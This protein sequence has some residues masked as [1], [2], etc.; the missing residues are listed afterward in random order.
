MAQRVRIGQIDCANPR[1]SRSADTAEQHDFLQDAVEHQPL[2]RHQGDL[3]EPAQQKL[4]QLG[5]VGDLKQLGGQHQAHPPAVA[6]QDGARDDEGDPGVGQPGGP[7]AAAPHQLQGRL[8]LLGCPV[9]E[10]DVGRVAR[11]RVPATC[12]AVAQPGEQVLD[13]DG[14]VSARLGRLGCDELDTAGPA[15]ERGQ[16]AQDRAVAAGRLQDLRPR[17][18][19]PAGQEPG[20]RGGGVV[21][22]ADLVRRRGRL[23]R[24][25]RH[26]RISKSVTATGSRNPTAQASAA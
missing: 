24:E 6:R 2:E 15:A 11:H 3:G 9:A 7:K 23:A 17:R 8:A 21:A 4:A 1:R 12:L 16:L 18:A 13:V 26:L 25:R 10:A 19:N 20:H 14:R 22:A 5:G